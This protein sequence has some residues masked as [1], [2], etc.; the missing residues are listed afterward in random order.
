MILYVDG[1]SSRAPDGLLLTGYAVCSDHEVIEKGKLTVSC[2]AQQAE[3][4][5]LIRAY[6][7]A[8][9]QIVTIYTDSGYA[10]GAVHKFGALWRERGFY[11][12]IRCTG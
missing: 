2:S 6:H 4:F 3:L 12:I 8:K 10:F 1:S 9:G 5:A 11:N 7:L